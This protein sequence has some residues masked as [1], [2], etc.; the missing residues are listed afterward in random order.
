[1][2]CSV[3]TLA[4]YVR[5][6]SGATKGPS[7]SQSEDVHRA[8][9]PLPAPRF[10]ALP[11]PSGRRRKPRHRAW[12]SNRSVN[13]SGSMRL[14]AMQ[15]SSRWACARPGQA[16][17]CSSTLQCATLTI[18]SRRSPSKYTHARPRA[19]SSAPAVSGRPPPTPA[20]SASRLHPEAPSD[21]ASLEPD[22]Q[23]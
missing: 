22:S 5:P 9:P 12:R 16:P 1:M 14:S 18:S 11:W 3:Y 17:C 15:S 13:A 2:Q 23:G 7:A 21:S 20:R 10:P 4:S 6:S 8:A 19:P